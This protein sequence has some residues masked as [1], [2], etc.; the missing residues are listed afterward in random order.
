M[1][2]YLKSIADKNIKKIKKAYS[3]LKKNIKFKYREPYIVDIK[4]KSNLSA[5]TIYKHLDA[6]GLSH[7]KKGLKF[8]KNSDYK[9]YYVYPDGKKRKFIAFSVHLELDDLNKFNEFCNKNRVARSKL[10]RALILDELKTKRL[11][12]KVK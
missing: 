8:K 12:S 9:Y 7:L 6:C 2:P 11:T 5:T 3:E 4:R 10:C 1:N